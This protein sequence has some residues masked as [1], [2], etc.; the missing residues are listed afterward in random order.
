MN[1]PEVVAEV[2]GEH[3]GDFDRMLRLI[4]A[5]QET[6]A[7]SVKFQCFSRTKMARDPSRVIEGGPWDG[8]T[9]GALYDELWTPW[10]W[11]PQ[12]AEFCDKIGMPWFSSV[13]D[14]DALEF[15][16]SIGCPRY[17]VSSFELTDLALIRAVAKT[18]KPI[19]LST[20]MATQTEIG[21]ACNVITG[22]WDK[23]HVWDCTLLHCVSAY[24]AKI[25]EMNLRTI[26]SLREHHSR[27]VGLSDHSP[28]WLAPVVAT[29][30]GASMIEKHLT[31]SRAD[32]GPDSAFALE[33]EEFAEMVRYVRQAAVARGEVR[34]G[35]KPSEQYLWLRRGPNGRGG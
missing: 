23:S 10:A 5:A 26:E 17:K 24:P 11:F 22:A 29:S 28:G 21:T 7:D 8:K 14:L 25:E 15:L 6:G 35:P 19:V 34:Y 2:S 9:L 16:E 18:G 32:G 3:K 20:G 33:P 30:L 31:L 1:S 12:L 4:L 27:R 13:F